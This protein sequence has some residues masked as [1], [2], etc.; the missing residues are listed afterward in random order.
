MYYAEIYAKSNF[1]FLEGASHPEELVR[2]AAELGYGA[3][4]VTDRNSLAGVVRASMAAKDT[5]IKLLVGAEIVLE[6]AASAVFLPTD[7]AAYGRLCR[8]ITEGRRRVEKGQCLLRMEDLV[9]HAEGMLACV[10]PETEVTTRSGGV[11][12]AVWG[13]LLSGRVASLRA[14]RSTAA[15]GIG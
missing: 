9:G 5:G 14:R 8:L 15:C 11:S 12:R 3:I 10:I 7:R 13:S 2:R 1:S 6:D 4:G